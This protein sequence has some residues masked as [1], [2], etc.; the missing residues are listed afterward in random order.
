LLNTLSFKTATAA[1]G[2]KP[3][4]RIDEVH[5]I[6]WLAIVGGLLC[7]NSGWVNAVAIRG[8]DGGVTG[9]SGTSTTVGLTLATLD[10]EAFLSS[11]AKILAFLSGAMISG[12]YLGSSRV[13]K[14]GPRYAHLLLLVSVAMAAASGCET[15]GYNFA[16]ALL[17]AVSSGVQN[18]L[19]TLYSGAVMR[20]THVTGTVTDMG[21]ELGKVVFQNDRTG[22]WKLKVHTCLLL[23]FIG[24]GFL[25]AVCFNPSAISGPDEIRAEAQAVLVPA[26]VTLAMAFSWLVSLRNAEPDPRGCGLHAEVVWRPPSASALGLHK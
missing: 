25:G 1:T 6:H 14:G 9:V 12:G 17:L 13:F 3:P 16:G 10:A 7:M 2:P 21:V 23:S 11:T 20:T 22:C 19:T 8:F 4:G 15:A 24:G 26:A 5:Q 18:A